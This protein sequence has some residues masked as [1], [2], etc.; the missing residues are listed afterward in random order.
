[1]SFAPP[2]LLLI[3]GPTASGKSSLALAVARRFVDE[4]RRSVILNADALQLYRDLRVLTA[5]PDAQDEA[6]VP[7]R[8][9]GVIDG[10]VR[11][12]VASWLGLAREEITAALA[13]GFVPIVVGGSG[14]YLHALLNGLAPVPEID[15]DVRAAA[16]LRHAALGGNR[17]R[18]ELAAL[19]PVSAGKLHDGDTQ[20]LI[21]AYE[22]VRS[23]G[24]PLPDWQRALTDTPPPEW[25][26]HTFVLEPSRPVLYDT[27]DRRFA[28]MLQ[29]GALDEV[30]ALLARNLP[31]DQPVMKAVG[32]PELAALIRGDIT[33]SVA[34][35]KAQQ[36]TRHYAKRQLTW[37]RHQLGT[38]T[39]L[40]ADLARDPGAVEQLADRIVSVSVCGVR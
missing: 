18:A 22:V 36:A 12:S 23:T 2:P 20:R 16:V 28:L 17:F 26:F 32:V 11:G 21:R 25:R 6:Q 19:D 15:P 14:L 9:Y 27:C 24:R 13:E 31:A 30:R 3:G 34:R 35:A 39:R 8:L 7:H 38:A 33:E 4:G 10:A 5:R 40:T 1:M 29:Q 37:F